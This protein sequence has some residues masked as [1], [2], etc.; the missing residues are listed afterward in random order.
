MH[1]AIVKCEVWTH[2]HSISIGQPYH[3]RTL[4][5]HPIAHCH[6]A[7]LVKGLWRGPTETDMLLDLS[8]TT[9]KSRPLGSIHELSYTSQSIRNRQLFSLALSN[10]TR[11]SL[12]RFRNRF[13][14]N[15][16]ALTGLAQSG[17]VS[18]WALPN[19][20]QTGLRN[21]SLNVAEPNHQTVSKRFNGSG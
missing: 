19:R 18:A 2:D 13:W 11:L 10:P 8:V 4:W 3:P 6:N 1:H 5:S 16:L 20:A 14:T 17:S 12:N 21:S 9:A 15:C 7:S